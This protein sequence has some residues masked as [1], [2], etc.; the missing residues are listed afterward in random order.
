[1][2]KENIKKVSNDFKNTI[3]QLAEPSSRFPV[4]F[5]MELHRLVEQAAYELAEQDNFKE[6]PEYYWL[7]AEKNVYRNH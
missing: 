6:S 3:K 5:E 7:A 1:M 2:A 4:A